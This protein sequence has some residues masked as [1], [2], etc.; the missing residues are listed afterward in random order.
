M[1]KITY[2]VNILVK[3]RVAVKLLSNMCI[4]NLIITFQINS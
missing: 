1:P 2:I 3:I 4:Y